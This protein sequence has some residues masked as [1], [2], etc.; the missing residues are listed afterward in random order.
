MTKFEMLYVKYLVKKP[1]LYYGFIAVF[2]TVFVAMSLFI[3]LDV[4]KSY[5]AVIDNDVITITADASSMAP[6]RIFYYANRNDAV[7][8]SEVTH[9]DYGDYQ[10][11]VTISSNSD[12][13]IRG[14]VT[15]DIVAGKQTLLERI[16]LKAGKN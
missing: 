11:F 16:F 14:A 8:S 13:K 2:V 1:W 7:Y 6:T 5:P 10:V 12:G 15:V 9:V 3:K 4:V